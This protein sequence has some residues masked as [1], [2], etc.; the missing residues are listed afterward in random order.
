M[1]VNTVMISSATLR[2]LLKLSTSTSRN[3]GVLAIQLLLVLA[4]VAVAGWCWI[5]LVAT[6]AFASIRPLSISLFMISKDVSFMA[7][8]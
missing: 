1:H 2:I 6:K 8:I 4:G 3:T 5:L 7:L